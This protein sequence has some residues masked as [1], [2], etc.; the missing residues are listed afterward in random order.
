MSCF[1]MA[2]ATLRIL[3]ISLSHQVFPCI[4]ITLFQILRRNI[5]IMDGSRFIQRIFWPNIDPSSNLPCESPAV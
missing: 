5:Q 3:E 2:L 1:T 4:C